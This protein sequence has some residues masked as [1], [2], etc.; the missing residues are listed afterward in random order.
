MRRIFLILLVCCSC[1][2]PRHDQRVLEVFEQLNTE[3]VR[4]GLPPLTLDE[5]RD[6][7]RRPECYRRRRWPTR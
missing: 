3:R 5:F 2:A 7:G 6:I 4:D 1:V